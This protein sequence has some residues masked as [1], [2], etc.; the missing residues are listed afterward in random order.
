MA[1]QISK[2]IIKAFLSSEEVTNFLK[3]EFPPLY[4]RTTFDHSNVFNQGSTGMFTIEEWLNQIN[5]FV[6][7]REF[8]PEERAVLGHYPNGAPIPVVYGASRQDVHPLSLKEQDAQAGLVP[9]SSMKQPEQKR[10][11]KPFPSKAMYTGEPGVAPL[12]EW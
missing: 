6:K 1:V 3:K 5:R 11:H 8:T 4:G 7:R 10:E 2:E 12:L 9:L